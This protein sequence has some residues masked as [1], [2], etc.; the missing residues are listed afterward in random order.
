M[1]HKEIQAGNVANMIPKAKSGRECTQNHSTVH[2]RVKDI[3][4]SRVDTTLSRGGM[5]RTLLSD[6]GAKVQRWPHSIQ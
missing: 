5:V 6:G 3:H 1:A 4:R 2:A